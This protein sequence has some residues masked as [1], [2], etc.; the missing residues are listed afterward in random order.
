MA[1][2]HLRLLVSRFQ[3]AF[4]KELADAIVDEV[5][6]LGGRAEV[7]DRRSPA[8]PDDVY[9][10]LPTHEYLVLE[11]DEHLSDQRIAQRTIGIT[12][13]QPT[14]GHFGVNVRA[15]RALGAVFDFSA[16]AVEA[17]ERHGVEC[18]H[19]PFGWTPTWDRFTSEPQWTGPD[20][21]FMGSSTKRRLGALAQVA[22]PLWQRPSRLIVSDNSIR[23]NS[24]SSSSFVAGPAKRSLLASVKVLL[25]LHQ[26]DEP[27][28]EWL[29][30]TEA[31]MCGAVVLTE[32]SIRMEPYVDGEHLVVR[33][34]AGM[35]HQLEELLDDES[36]LFA[37]RRQAY[38]AVRATPF[39]SA[40]E[41]LMTVAEDVRA[42]A[43]EVRGH[44]G[45]T[46]TIPYDPQPSA[47]RS[48]DRE[49]ADVVRQAIREIRLDLMDVRR[50][51][52][53]VQRIAAE[54]AD[55]PDV[56]FRSAAQVLANQPPRV[57]VL[58]AVYNHRSF[59]GQ[60]L[61]TAANAGFDDLELVV[62]DDGSSDGSLDAA[63][64][65]M[66]ANPDVRAT[67]VAMPVNSGLPKARNAA[68]AQ[69]QGEYCFVLD[70]DNEVLPD[71][72][73]RLVD[74]LDAH[75][76]AS[77]AY[78]VLE[79]F[80]AQGSVGLMGELPWD[81]TRLPHGNYIDAMALIRRSVFADLGGYT[82]DRRLYGWEDY[83]LWCRIAE[84]GGYGAH[85]PTL[86]A[87]YRLAMSS[88]VALSNLSHDAAFDALSE[89]APRL[90]SGI[91]GRRLEEVALLGGAAAAE[92]PS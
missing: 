9:V 64:A 88:M 29:R 45:P 68:V 55:G 37:V 5:T 92:V 85:V 91:L 25:N 4:F 73:R 26:T 35:A 28:F 54:I 60:G 59:L 79:T 12:A 36:R 8:G 75:P 80:G 62:V 7:V 40:V 76:G 51:L 22:R 41:R 48:H 81:V 82:T 84:A 23:P 13:E 16:H 3:N 1:D 63:R 71:G 27:Y 44:V 18:H 6:R 43:E 70:A 67:L 20:I 31:M 42:S 87:R 21:L 24:A 34:V 33:A 15:G 78:G 56:V 57:S 14:S 10:L 65:W 52:Q 47:R 39:R 38:E 46:R 86:V 74:A 90:M 17:Y 66:E 83:D 61:S 30:V 53:A 49:Q 72:I 69:A 89:R 32:P 11:G 58:M 50:Q 2:V 77:F 19:L